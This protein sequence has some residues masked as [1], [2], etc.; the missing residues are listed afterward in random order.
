[1][2][3]RILIGLWLA[4]AGMGIL[5]AQVVSPIIDISLIEDQRFGR[6]RPPDELSLG[7]ET[8]S[9]AVYKLIRNGEVIKAG[10]LRRGFN[11]I[12]FSCGDYFR[13]S[14][15]HELIFEMRES[16]RIRRREIEL[17]IRLDSDIGPADDILEFKDLSYKLSLLIGETR[18]AGSTRKHYEK[19]PLTVRLPDLPLDH[20]PYDPDW[21]SDPLSNSFSILHALALVVEGYK[22]IRKRT[23]RDP[24]K[25]EYETKK[26]IVSR[27]MR[28]EGEKRTAVHYAIRLTTRDIETP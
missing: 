7:V 13:S 14:G 12:G 28:G 22:E 8:R 21:K 10:R 16:G 1:M 25:Y 11:F 18:V 6:D 26:V 20:R 9:G 23:S 24:Y 4:G 2:G 3:R 19:F 15:V 5:S 27:F 17:D